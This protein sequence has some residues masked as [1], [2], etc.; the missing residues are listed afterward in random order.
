MLNA[1][2]IN[3]EA[4]NDGIWVSLHNSSF[5]IASVENSAFKNAVFAA[6][7]KQFTDDEFCKILADTILLGWSD[8][9]QPD[10]SELVYS[11]QMAVIALQVNDEVRS[12][13]DAVS[14]NLGLFVE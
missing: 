3:S 1:I 7:K 5:L 2:N 14:T 6:G 10:G 12:L 11:K 8:V 13:V 4:V 9:K